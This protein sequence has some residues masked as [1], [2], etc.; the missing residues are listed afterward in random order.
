VTLSIICDLLGGRPTA[1]DELAASYAEAERGP[2]LIDFHKPGVE[3][4]S[5]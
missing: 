2:T 4:G 3:W 1:S 5:A